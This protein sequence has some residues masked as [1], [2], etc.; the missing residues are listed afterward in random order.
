MLLGLRGEAAWSDPELSYETNE[1]VPFPEIKW[2]LG[3]DWS[4]GIWRFT[5]EYSGKYIADYTPSSVEPL[6][7]TELDISQIGGTSCNPGI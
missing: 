3:A 6:I 5:G 7:G 4:T 2:A 1:Y